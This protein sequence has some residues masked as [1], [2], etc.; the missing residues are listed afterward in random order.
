MVNGVDPML[1]TVVLCAVL[2]VP[3]VWAENVRLL[4]V[5]V[6]TEVTPVPERLAVCGLLL[7]LSET[8]SVPWRVP[9]V[10]GVKVTWI[11]QLPAE[12]R[13]VPQLFVWAKSPLAPTLLMLSELD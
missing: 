6:S 10:V 13:L 7:P 11:V 12:A 2:V 3:A 9:V 8:V 5:K 1:L 4:G